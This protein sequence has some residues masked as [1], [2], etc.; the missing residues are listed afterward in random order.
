M[1][2]TSSARPGA[3]FPEVLTSVPTVARP[4]VP[5]LALA[6][7]AAA[8]CPTPADAQEPRPG[9]NVR[10]S[11]ALPEG[12]LPPDSASSPV[13]IR[14]RVTAAEELGPMPP[15]LPGRRTGAGYGLLNIDLTALG[16]VPA[17]GDR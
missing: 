11:D 14:A 12:G 16:R 4:P 7:S 13:E 6:L 10:I 5:A 8:L 1:S 3:P 17:G 9:E 15:P 2:I